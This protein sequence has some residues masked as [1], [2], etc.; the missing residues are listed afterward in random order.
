MDLARTIR[1]RSGKTLRTTD[2]AKRYVLKMLKVRPSWNS[3]KHAAKL[4]V[5]D[6]SAKAVTEQ[7]EFALFVQC[8]LDVVF[9]EDQLRRRG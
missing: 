5:E 4:L 1:D 2:E 6:G 8:D 3:W 9:A 7:I